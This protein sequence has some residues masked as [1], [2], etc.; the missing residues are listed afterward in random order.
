MPDFSRDVDIGLLQAPETTREVIED[1]I[2]S[3]AKDIKSVSDESLD[4][5]GRIR[6]ANELI[7]GQEVE[8]S[9]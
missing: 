3:A 2:G 9:E 1:V 5:L 4:E 7:L 8:E 6:R